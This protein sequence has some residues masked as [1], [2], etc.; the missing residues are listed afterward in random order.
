MNITSTQHNLSWDEADQLISILRTWGI[1]YLV[2]ENH[3]RS[4]PIYRGSPIH[5][6]ISIAR[7]Q[8]TTVRLI[9]RLAQCEYPRVR[10]ASISLF[11][12]HPELAPAVLEAIQ[13]SEPAVAEQIMSLVLATLYLQRLWSPRLTIA[14]G[15]VPCF[16]E[17]PFVDL[18]RSRQLPPPSFYN[19]QWGLRALQAFEQR[20]TGLPLNFLHDWQ[21]Q[22]DHLLLQEEAHYHHPVVPVGQVLKEDQ[23]HYAEENVDMSMRPKVDK[24]AIDNFLK[25]LGRAFR[26]PGRLYLVRG[27][28]LV[29]RG[30]RAGTTL[31]IDVEVSG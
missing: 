26:K 28:A 20:R 13:V 7:D 23:P 8:Q 1:D 6:G 25:A 19:A 9:Q 30:V 11:L 3:P 14:L 31:D 5:R 22:V 16:P 18:W 17:E 27:A 29:H 15:H 10:D 24:A 4:S 2:G 12:L 21:N